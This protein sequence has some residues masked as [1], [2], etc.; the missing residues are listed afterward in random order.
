MS[1]LP[2]ETSPLLK[3]EKEGEFDLWS[4]H[5]R[6]LKSWDD[7]LL[8]RWL[9]QNLTQLEEH[10]WR[11]SH[12]IVVAYRLGATVAHQRDLWNRRTFTL[13]PHYQRAACCNGPSI[14]FVSFEVSAYGFYC[15]C[16]G[17]VLRRIDDFPSDIAESF[18][19]WG[20]A[21]DQFHHIAHWD[22]TERAKC[23]N[24][25]TE[26][27]QAAEKATPLLSQLGYKLAPKLLLQFPAVIWEDSDAC[28]DIIPEDLCPPEEN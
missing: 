21:Y 8:A 6:A 14:P 19:K 7:L 18:N 13:N 17:E 5:A 9:N 27:D 28:L 25:E 4:E 16:C 10:C 23:K 2:K 11:A 26:V 24:F 12:P 3:I 20:V 1:K 15:S 22:E